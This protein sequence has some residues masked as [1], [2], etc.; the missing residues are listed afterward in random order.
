MCQQISSR[1]ARFWKF[2]QYLK[3]VDWRAEVV[4]RSHTLGSD[5]I[6]PIHRN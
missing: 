4:V 1:L 3:S 2:F 5:G 6:F